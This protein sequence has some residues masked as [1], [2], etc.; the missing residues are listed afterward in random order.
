M[1]IY[2]SFLII[3]ILFSCQ[4]N[5]N[6]AMEHNSKES[7]SDRAK[8]LASKYNLTQSGFDCECIYSK[9]DL[10]KVIS[11]ILKDLLPEE[12][13]EI[14]ETIS[15]D[16]KQYVAKVKH[17]G[18]QEIEMFAGIHADFLPEGFSYLLESIPSKIG[19]D[20]R[21]FMINPRLLGQDAWYFCGTEADLNA[22]KKE[23]LPLIYSGEDFMEMDISEFE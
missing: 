3:A 2:I 19:S 20:K 5:T 8:R 6:S 23:G 13:F 14:T 7:L 21:F 18:G 9:G 12:Q 1:R 10:T 4:T 17:N 15:Q 16:R 22:A 11:S